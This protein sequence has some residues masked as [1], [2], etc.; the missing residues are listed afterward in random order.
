[1]LQLIINTGILPLLTG[2]ASACYAANTFPS[3]PAALQ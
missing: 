2:A 3:L 1:M